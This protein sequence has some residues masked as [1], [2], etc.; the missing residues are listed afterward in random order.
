[1]SGFSTI[2]RFKL[3]HITLVFIFAFLGSA[4]LATSVGATSMPANV[5]KI[6][7]DAQYASKD[8][9]EVLVSEFHNAMNN[10]PFTAQCTNSASYKSGAVN[11]KDGGESFNSYLKWTNDGAGEYSNDWIS[12]TSTLLK[13]LNGEIG[14]D[15]TLEYSADNNN[16]GW[17]A[18]IVR[19]ATDAK[20]PI[21][22]K[23]VNVTDETDQKSAAI[24]D[25]SNKC[26]AVFSDASKKVLGAPATISTFL[27]ELSTNDYNT[28]VGPY[29]LKITGQSAG[30][31]ACDDL[32]KDLQPKIDE[33]I[34][35][36]CQ[37]TP[38]ADGCTSGGTTDGGATNCVVEGIGWIVCPV[39]NFMGGVVDAA[40]GWVASMLKVQPLLTTGD[41][42]GVYNAWSAMRSI[43]N[44]AFVIAFLFIIF[45]QLTSVGVSNYGV[46]KMLPRLVI[47]A[48]LVNLSFWICAAAV[49][50]SNIIGSSMVSLFNSI[51]GSIKPPSGVDGSATGDGAWGSWGAL[52]ALVLASAAVYYVMLSALIPA[53]LAAFV[54]IL[55]VFLVL[56]LRQA[57][58][59]LL[60]VIAP[61]AFVAYLLPNTE[62]W[63]TKWRKLLFTLLLMFPIIAA[64]FG[65]SSLASQIVMNSANGNMI[66][67]IMG[68]A[69][70]II[71]L[72]ITPVVMKAAGGILNRFAG[73]VN[74]AEKGPIDRLRKAGE[75]Y[76]QSRLNLRNSKALS[77]ANQLGRGSILRWR[78]RRAAIA[79]GREDASKEARRDYI[80]EKLGDSS[81]FATAVAAGDAK[82]GAQLADRA[83]AAAEAEDLKQALEPLRRTLATLDPAEKAKYLEK[84][85][86][87]GNKTRANAALHYSASIGDTGF[88]RKQIENGTNPDIVR[89]ARQAVDAN[90]SAIKGKAPDLVK[91]VEGAFK[92]F[93]GADMAQWD[94]GTA[95]AFSKYV[96]NNNARST[97]PRLNAADQQKALD[98]YN[99]SVRSFNSASED[100]HLSPEQQSVF[101]GETGNAI[102]RNLQAA[103]VDP[104]VAIAMQAGISRFDVNGKIR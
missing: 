41:T 10:A 29:V 46:K 55:T 45:S 76:H 78:A 42:S 24:S 59:I 88:L 5:I 4:A 38:D 6:I 66:V 84:E 8:D 89:M 44:I 17:C 51:G 25:I 94:K 83:V 50:L 57:L 7:S 95:A 34:A 40:Y 82:K 36:I 21:S 43:A 35:S 39:M 93:N 47:A 26:S 53:V 62:D 70:S 20:I 103:G 54:A 13:S 32:V 9:M 74:N 60:I 37:Q 67:Q 81:R 63:F 11:K 99:A 92:S 65:A 85:V 30:S 101:K 61:L 86:Q 73:I 19:M 12:K 72:A 80:A 28:L 98:D 71:P 90:A 68:A 49:D 3:K 104:S 15:M 22:A 1:M 18:F 91:G 97:D 77:G 16:E 100:I 102:I 52:I 79:G 2:V 75:G 23:A 33:K 31:S 58:I 56:A 48:I 64:I 96:I 14:G 87:S 27:N 69:I